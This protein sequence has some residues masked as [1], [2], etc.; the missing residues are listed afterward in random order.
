MQ[1]YLTRW[2]KWKKCVERGQKSM[3]GEPGMQKGKLKVDV[4]K[5]L[6]N[7]VK[8]REVE[9]NRGLRET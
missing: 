7:I 4:R 9:K 2:R 1:D 5:R 6:G 3:S 8:V